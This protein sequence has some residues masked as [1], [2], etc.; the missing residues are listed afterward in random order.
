MNSM[1][2]ASIVNAI[3]N[4]SIRNVA[5]L[6]GAGVSVNAGIPD[7]RSPGGLYDTLR[8]ERITATDSQRRMMALDPTAV[9]DIDL[10]SYNQFPY[11]EVRRPFILGTAEQRWKA[12]LT[13]FFFKILQEKSLLRRLYT[14]NI[15]GLDYQLSLP[16][17]KIV[18]V[19]GSLAV[20][21]CE[22]CRAP[23]P[24]DKFCVEVR[25]K[26]KN[27]YDDYEDPSA[28]RESSN[29]LCTRCHKPGVKPST[30]LYGSSLPKAF[31]RAVQ[32]D[33]PDQVDLLIVAGTS[34]TVSP[35]N[36]LVK[37]V[38]SGVPRLVIN[39]E[40]VGE[41]LGIDFNGTDVHISGDCDEA[42]LRLSE[43]L[44]WI[45]DIW[46][47]ADHMSPKSQSILEDRYGP[48]ASKERTKG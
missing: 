47:Y 41:D 30:V 48:S 25:N 4:G 40:R 12:T 2:F 43:A 44:G 8:P 21:E 27:I 19:H 13:H 16:K 26:I 18:N 9:V 11:L 31:F 33:F 14:Q 6:T 35:A 10:F 3:A 34:L 1:A 7:F 23:Y 32:D 29:I 38:K 36:Q 17:D 15:D 46:Q 22:F 39:R 37:Q 24:M 45:D 28:P 5:V 42:I 20:V